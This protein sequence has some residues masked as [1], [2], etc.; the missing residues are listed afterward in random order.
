MKLAGPVDVVGVGALSRE[1]AEILLAA[2]SSA[3]AEIA[4][5]PTLRP[6]RVWRACPADEAEA[7][8]PERPTLHR[9]IASRTVF[10][11]APRGERTLDPDALGSPRAESLVTEL[12]L[13]EYMPRDEPPSGSTDAGPLTS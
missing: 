2:H 1:E 5:E 10:A 8:T 11:L 12:A 6:Y 4:H 9:P 13:F 3:D 7:D